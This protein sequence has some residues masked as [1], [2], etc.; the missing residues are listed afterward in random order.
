MDRQ[1]NFIELSNNGNHKIVK[2]ATKTSLDN[3]A[4]I[5]AM[6]NKVVTKRV[7][8]GTKV[9]V[10]SGGSYSDMQA[11]M[12]DYPL[13]CNKAIVIKPNSTIWFGYH[14]I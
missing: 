4:T 9:V 11:A 7:S 13:F 6:E 8:C 2:Q 5:L 12:T 3:Y 10:P 14:D 1:D